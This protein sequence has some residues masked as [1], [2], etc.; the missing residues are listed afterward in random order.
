MEVGV[1]T[2]DMRVERE[3]RQ[4]E[5]IMN[6]YGEGI[7]DA[8]LLVEW[9]FVEGEFTGNGIEWEV[10]ELLGEDSEVKEVWE[11]VI[12]RGAIVLDLFPD[13]ED[14]G[15]DG[16]RLIAP[17]TDSPKGDPDRTILNLNHNGQISLHIWSALYLTSHS[18]DREIENFESKIINSVIQVETANISPKPT[19]EPETL[20]TC[21][22][23]VV[24][25]QKRLDGMYRPEMTMEELLDRRDV[26]CDPTYLWTR[27]ADEKGL[28]EEKG[29]ERMAMTV[30]IDERALIISALEQ[31]EGL[32]NRVVDL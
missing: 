17:P 7:G 2:V 5:E 9:G 16:G 13:G 22:Q 32:L 26:S 10:E 29:D 31:W 30:A 27:P 24:L 28:G 21:R 20:M 6:T 8:R 3:V 14:D 4:D 19:L 11:G 23:I 18:L 15:E 25:L 12:Q 1:D